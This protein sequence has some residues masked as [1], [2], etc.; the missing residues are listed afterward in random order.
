MI[1]NIFHISALQKYGKL[2]LSAVYY[3][4]IFSEQFNIFGHKKTDAIGIR[5]YGH[6]IITTGYKPTYP[7]KYA[8][9][10]NSKQ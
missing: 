8:H 6:S 10:L 7:N 3:R 1:C 9:T 5:C 2:C 4:S